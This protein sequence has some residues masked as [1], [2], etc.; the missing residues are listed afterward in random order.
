[1]PDGAE[2]VDLG[3]EPTPEHNR[4]ML[5]QWGL[6][7]IM[8][9]ERRR[10]V[11]D[12]VKAKREATHA[13]MH[14]ESLTKNLYETDKQVFAEETYEALHCLTSSLLSLLDELERQR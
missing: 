6:R 13:R 11:L 5:R 14:A 7:A 3:R 4:N 8:E 10:A 9:I 12:L 2:F 1:M